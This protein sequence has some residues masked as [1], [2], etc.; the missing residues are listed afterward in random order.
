M[1]QIIG[2]LNK[3]GAAIAADS[4]GSQSINKYNKI[5]NSQNKM[6]R[7]SVSCDDPVSVMILN[8]DSLL[9][10]PWDV[11]ARCYR[12]ERNGKTFPVFHEYVSDFIQYVENRVLSDNYDR[13]EGLQQHEWSGLVF[14]GY[15]NEEKYP[16]L[17]VVN[18]LEVDGA[19]LIYEINKAVKISDD[20]PYEF[21]S[22]GQDDVVGQLFEGVNTDWIRI[23]A[24]DSLEHYRSSLY[25]ELKNLPGVNKD[26]LIPLRRVDIDG[27]CDN[28]RD[29]L[30][31]NLDVEQDFKNLSVIEHLSVG[32]MAI[33]A[34]SM[35]CATKLHRQMYFQEES[36]GG[37]V[38]L[39]TITKSGFKWIDR[40]CWYD[41]PG[42]DGFNI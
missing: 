38:D 31:E 4:A 11:I 40:K 3:Q 17:E 19:H 25:A 9:G 34:N 24:K 1:T 32:E 42:Q 23:A 18:I 37:L 21:V 41:A 13:I 30:V 8:N 15:G 26:D 35:I 12:S 27:R 36:V 7:L 5:S 20:C 28:F 16:S 10:I 39:A 22:L 2:F 14:T 6:V 33:L 29:L